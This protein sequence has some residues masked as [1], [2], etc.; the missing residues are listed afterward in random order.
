MHIPVLQL[1]LEAALK[2]LLE[3]VQQL[4]EDTQLE[5]LRLQLERM[6]HVGGTKFNKIEVKIRIHPV[7]DMQEELAEIF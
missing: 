4:P 7:V 2:A 1:E 6:A 5:G 3:H